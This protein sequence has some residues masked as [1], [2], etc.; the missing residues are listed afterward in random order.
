MNHPQV[1]LILSDIDGTLQPAGPFTSGPRA[2]AAF[3]A[4]IDV[5]IHC[6]GASGRNLDRVF[7]SFG[8][9]EACCAT[10]IGSDGMEVCLDGEMIREEFLPLE[11][12]R[13]AVEVM[14][15]VPNSF[16]GVT[17]GD[18]YYLITGS[19]EGLVKGDPKRFRI[20]ETGGIVPD[21][22]TPKYNLFLMPDLALTLDLMAHLEAAAPELDFHME[23][24]G[25]LS[26]TSKGCNK[27]T[28]VQLICDR[29]GI[30][31]DEV[32]VFGD[33][34]NDVEMLSYVPNSVAVENASPEAAAA[35]R[36]HIG[37]VDDDAVPAA[38]EELAAG[39]WPFVR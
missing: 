11:G 33:S 6:G 20:H 8:F 29:L 24:P 5:G 21:I 2:I 27:A 3:H 35:A 32:V 23:R 14:R 37:S 18:G 9:D 26:A 10:A 34:G 36:W 13:R 22:R 38:I 1:K 17:D 19:M 16:S 25:A 39:R 12:V 15:T 30:A 7:H 31:L 4:A 28:A